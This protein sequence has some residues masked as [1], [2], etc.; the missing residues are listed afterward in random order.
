MLTEHMWDR[1]PSDR[2]HIA[3]LK[4]TGSLIAWPR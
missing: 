3:V 4:Q 1:R 2:D